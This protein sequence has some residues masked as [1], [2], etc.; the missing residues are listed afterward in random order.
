M[1]QCRLVLIAVNVQQGIEHNKIK[2]FSQGG[3]HDRTKKND[4]A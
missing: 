1:K 4:R 2:V 3:G